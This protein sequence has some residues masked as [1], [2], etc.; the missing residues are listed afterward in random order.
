MRV[1]LTPSEKAP[2]MRRN[3]TILRVGGGSFAC[4]L[5][6]LVVGAAGAASPQLPTI[7][8]PGVNPKRLVSG[9][10]YRAHLFPL[11]LRVKIPAGAWV[12]A[13][14]TSQTAKAPPAFGWVE[15]GQPPP[16]E[17]KGLLQIMTSYTKTTPV[18]ATLQS[19]RMR[20]VGASYQP[21]R[22]VTVAGMHG[23][24]F[25]GQ[26]TGAKGHNFIPFTPPNQAGNSLPKDHFSMDKGE[27]FRI[28]VLSIR[29]K[30]V[31]IAEENFGLPPAQFPDFLAS[32]DALLNSL[33]FT[34]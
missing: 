8:N 7:P 32:A 20:G 2:E 3:R 13:Q 30:T 19:L 12:G 5:A 18:A 14:W 9:S 24:Q 21:T 16:N 4:A 11:P 27:V 1:L 29:G 31:V 6:G 23:S 22:S 26:V 10:V 28:T 15:F 33:R 17:A 34:P 25:D